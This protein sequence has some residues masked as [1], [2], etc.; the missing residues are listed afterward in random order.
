MSMDRDDMDQLVDELDM[1]DFLSWL[2]VDFRNTTGQSGPQLNIKTCPRCGGSDWKVFLN[3][4]SGLGNC[5]HGSCV[6]EPGYNKIT[7]AK[8]LLGSFREA[9]REISSYAAAAGWRPPKPKTKVKTTLV[10][11]K[12]ATASSALPFQD[13][14]IPMDEQMRAV[15]YLKARNIGKQ[16]MTDLGWR[17]SCEGVYDY[18]DYNGE[19]KTQ[20]Y[21]RRI[22]APIFDLSGKLVN[23]QGRDITNTQPK[24]YIFPPGLPGTGRFLYNSHSAVG[25]ITIIIGEGVFDV[26]AILQAIREDSSLS[27]IGVIGSFGKHLSGDPMKDSGAE[28]QLSQL[29]QLKQN[30]LKN[31]VFMW[32]GESK[33][34][35]D[36]IKACEQIRA[37]DL[38]PFVAILPDGKDPNEVEPS[39]VRRAYYDRIE[40]T[41]TAALRYMLRHR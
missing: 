2:H 19:A 4:E 13:S 39:E 8:H 15:N 40:M 16:T 12:L 32:D 17:Y 7:F 36:A 22:V 31:V 25:L 14:P 34:V 29:I 5:F 21:S 35:M 33:T 26:A 23:F 1:E 10:G 18:V 28:D 41:K 3:A 6:G 9:F 38:R 37:I 24:K 11:E 27:D 20:Y 30:G